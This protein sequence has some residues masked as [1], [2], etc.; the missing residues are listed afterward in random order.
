[1]PV[2]FPNYIC[3]ALNDLHHVDEGQWCLLHSCT[4]M[5]MSPQ[6]QHSL[7]QKLAY[8]HASCKRYLQDV[9]SRTANDDVTLQLL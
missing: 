4:S 3:K 9:L 1:M 6:E 2:Q 8:V 5:Q 7:P